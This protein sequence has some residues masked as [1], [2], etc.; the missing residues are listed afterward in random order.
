[1]QSNHFEGKTLKYLAIEPEGYTPGGDYPMVVLLHGFGANMDD[2]AGLCPAINPEGY[3]YICPNA[4]LSVEIGMGMAGYAW[5]P[6]GDNRTADDID[7]AESLLA[8]LIEE[9]TAQY[10]VRP[11]NMI[12]GGFSQGGM[13]TYRYGLPNPQLFAGIMALSTRV[14]DADEMRKRLPEKRTQP[15]FISHGHLDQMI[16][17]EEGQGSRDF[18]EAEGYRP[19]YREYAMGHEI[20]Q[21]V[22]S[23]VV[24]WIRKVLPPYKQ[25]SQAGPS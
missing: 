24:T 8:G 22:L 4:P 11:G 14:P 21:E 6:P 18:L 19:E 12:L 16:S 17:I 9:V 3:V 1:M 23:D 25:G 10:D 2:L 15:I 13:M 20:S 5:T 7:E